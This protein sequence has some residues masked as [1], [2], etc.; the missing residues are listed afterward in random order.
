MLIDSIENKQKI[1]QKF[2][3]LCVFDG[4]NDSTLDKAFLGLGIDLKSMDLIFE[5]KSLDVA[6]FWIENINSQLKEKSLSFD[7]KEMKIRD[8]ITILLKTQIEIVKDYKLQIKQLIDFY[9]T[10]PQ[11]I[12]IAI[13][14]AYKSADLMWYS[15]GDNSTDF[16]FYSK[17]IILS[18]IYMKTFIFFIKDES[19]NNKET[20][21]FIDSQIEKVM[22][23]TKFKFTVRNKAQNLKKMCKGVSDLK[24]NIKEE[25]SSN[26]IKKLPF[27]RL[28]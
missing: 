2:L 20:Y 6:N 10:K 14:N 3:D 11:N 23:F 7:L 22:K 21:N 19:L 5:N 18:K 4:W 27:F 25:G 16:N 15:I 17:R 24:R 1:L 9:S 13:G 26:F 28:Y 12:S 8:K